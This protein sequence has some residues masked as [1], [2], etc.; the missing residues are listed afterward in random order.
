MMMPDRTSNN[1]EQPSMLERV[2]LFFQLQRGALPVVESFMGA[3]LD[4]PVALRAVLVSLMDASLD[5]LSDDENYALGLLRAMN[6]LEDFH[7][8]SVQVASDD[9][10]DDDDEAALDMSEVDLESIK[11]TYRT[12]IAAIQLCFAEDGRDALKGFFMAFPNM[13]GLKHFRALQNGEPLA[14]MVVMYWAVLLDRM[15]E[16][17]WYCMQYGKQILTEFSERLMRH[18]IL[19]I[20]EVKQSIAWARKEVGLDSLA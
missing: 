12:S 17:F 11:Q 20:P 1:C 2:Q 7:R 3:M 10:D 18:P 5:Y 6:E 8:L 4:S 9:D 14:L 19:K 15:R 13:S 16:D